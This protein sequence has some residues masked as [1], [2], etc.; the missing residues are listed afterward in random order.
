MS[1]EEVVTLKPIFNDVWDETYKTKYGTEQNKRN[2][3]IERF[4][5][6]MKK[7]ITETV[8]QGIKK[9]SRHIE[10]MAT[11][12]E[13]MATDVGNNVSQNFKK[14]YGI[15][16]DEFNV[17][18]W[19]KAKNKAEIIFFTGLN[20]IIKSRLTSSNRPV[21]FDEIIK[22]NMRDKI[23][24][25]NEIDE[26]NEIKKTGTLRT[27]KIEDFKE[28]ADFG[29]Y[30]DIAPDIINEMEGA[31]LIEGLF[32]PSRYTQG[33]MDLQFEDKNVTTLLD[34]KSLPTPNKENG[35]DTVFLCIQPQ[36]HLGWGTSK[37][38]ILSEKK[39]EAKKEEKKEEEKKEE[40]KKE[41]EKKEENIYLDDGKP[42]WG[43]FDVY[44]DQTNKQLKYIIMDGSMSGAR[45]G[46]KKTRGKNKKNTKK[47]RSRRRR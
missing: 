47:G 38:Y 7:K 14:N 17:Y 24:G 16:G 23:D 41:E 29:H 8:Q 45:L 32:V 19:N 21:L 26:S 3:E 1:G 27:L 36:Q 30:S 28:G 39:E 40:E 33:F 34:G 42:K 15:Q 20:D 10:Q 2:M 13:Q 4:K 31:L 43:N 22:A 11:D 6:E 5:D 18:V 44:Y 35:L 12:V 25:S 46:G 9:Q 37:A